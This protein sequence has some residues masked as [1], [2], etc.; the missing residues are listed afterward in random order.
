MQVTATSW[1]FV[2]SLGTMEACLVIIWELHIQ[3]KYGMHSLFSV[4]L[5]LHDT[6]FFFFFF[7]CLCSAGM[8]VMF[9][10]LKE[11]NKTNLRLD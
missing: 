2:S 3:Q 9:C 7:W 11:K 8:I 4:Y 1:N 6:T 5:F 10:S